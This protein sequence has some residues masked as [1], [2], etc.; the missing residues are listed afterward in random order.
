MGPFHF[1]DLIAASSILTIA[2][3]LIL[4]HLLHVVS[5]AAAENVHVE[6]D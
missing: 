3:N 4:V 2:S 1:T 5:A 6:Q